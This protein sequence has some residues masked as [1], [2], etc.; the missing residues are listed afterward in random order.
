MLEKL[1]AWARLLEPAS[2]WLALMVAVWAVFA[3]MVFVLEPLLV[4]RLFSDYAL[5]D[6]DHAFAW[7]IWLHAVAL[8]ASCVAIA[9]GVL[10]AHGALS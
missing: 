6:K 1:H 4:H 9:A 7:A 2:W 3:L 10:G 5:R 8:T